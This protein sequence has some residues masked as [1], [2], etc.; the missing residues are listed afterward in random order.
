MKSEFPTTGN[1]FEEITRRAMEEFEN[2]RPAVIEISIDTGGEEMAT[3][4]VIQMPDGSFFG[5]KWLDDRKHPTRTYP[6]W[7]TRRAA[8]AALK[9]MKAGK[10]ER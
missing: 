9:K 10:N 5:Q 8:S 4:F 7:R 1:V 3:T 6:T 2:S